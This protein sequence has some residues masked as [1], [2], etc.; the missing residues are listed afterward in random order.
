MLYHRLT[1]GSAGYGLVRESRV[2]EPEQRSLHT[3][4]LK[5][6]RAV[7]SVYGWEKRKR[8]RIP[9]NVWH[10]P[11][12][13]IRVNK[14]VSFIPYYYDGYSARIIRERKEDGAYRYIYSGEGLPE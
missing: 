4:F 11:I 1:R 7:Q 10:G 14:P 2:P 8:Y 6:V 12:R 5:E 3:A 13:F 9:P